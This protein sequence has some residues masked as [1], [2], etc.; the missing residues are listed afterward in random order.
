M[1]GTANHRGWGWIRKRASGR[2]Q[3][4]YIGPDGKRYFAP[5][6][7]ERKTDAEGWLANERRDIDAAMLGDGNWTSPAERQTAVMATLRDRK[8][9]EQYGKEWIAQRDLKPRSR[10]H[11]S[12][13]LENHISPK[14]GSIAVSSLKSATVRSW[15]ANTLRNRPTMRSHA[16]QLLHAI[17]ETAV[18]DELLP[19]NPCKIAGATAV[20]RSREPVVP[21]IAELAVI[22]DKIEAKFRALVLIS[23]WCALRFGEVTE[24]RRKDIRF[25]DTNG[26][27]IVPGIVAVERGVTHRNDGDGD[28][29]RIDTPKSGK[30]RNVPIP[31]HIRADIQ[32]HLDCFVDSEP[33][34]LLFVPARGGC[35]VSDRVVR[36]SFRVACDA[37][38]VSG[39]RLHDLRHFAGHQTARVANLPE[40]M[41]RLGHSTQAASLRYQG[42]VSGRAAEIAEALSALATKPAL[43]T[44]VDES[45]SVTG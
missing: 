34:S 15:Y 12:A 43:V 33:E 37:A 8:T 26:D 25:I 16:Y 24:L 35:H 20:K 13:I 9:L 21:E 42:Q 4:S 28:R 32:T 41:A 19:S 31:P 44:T 39:M 36:A 5:A 3:A 40:T 1:S 23:A 38:N 45:P 27:G 30:T 29:C 10:I 18:A 2:Y 17:C 7:F 14:L 11:Y 6:T 22:A